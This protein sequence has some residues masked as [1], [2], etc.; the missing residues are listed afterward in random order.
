MSTSTLFSHT[1]PESSPGRGCA[2]VPAPTCMCAVSR[3][4]RAPAGFGACTRAAATRDPSRSRTY[5]RRH[6]RYSHG[7]SAHCMRASCNGHNG[8]FSKSCVREAVAAQ[9]Q[10]RACALAN[11]R[12]SKHK[13]THTRTH[14]HTN[15]RRHAHTHTCAHPLNGGERRL[16]AVTG[17]PLRVGELLQRRQQLKQPRV[18]QRSRSQSA[19]A[20]QSHLPLWPSGRRAP[21][22]PTQC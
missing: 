9:A 17:G 14:A 15:T 5:G 7:Y 3:R 10:P 2:R 1:C 16:R 8:S 21:P 22:I 13:H 19:P 6:S 12:W 20:Y 4:T 11:A 18:L